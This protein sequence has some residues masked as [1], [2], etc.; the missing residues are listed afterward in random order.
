MK[1][2]GFEPTLDFDV[3]IFADKTFSTYRKTKTHKDYFFR[4]NPF[5]MVNKHF[6]RQTD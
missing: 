2:E 1:K 4:W 5:N 6:T 3:G